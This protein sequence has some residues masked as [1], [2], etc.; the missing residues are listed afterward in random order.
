MTE[1][2]TGFLIGN[3][4]LKRGRLFRTIPLFMAAGLLL[5]SCA[6]KG[7]VFT[8]SLPP[9]PQPENLTLAPGDE[10][11]VRFPYFPEYDDTQII[12][13]DGK[14]S[15]PLIDEVQAEGLAPSELD[16]LLTNLYQE[17]I[18]E[19]DLTVVVRAQARKRVYVGGEVIF[20]GVIEW[21]SEMTVID[22]V[23]SAGGWDREHGEA[24]CVVVIRNVDG[25]YRGTTVDIRNALECKI[26]SPVYLAPDDIVYVPQTKISR[27]NQWV[28]Q[29]INRIFPFTPVTVTETRGASTV[30]LGL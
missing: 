14:I 19:P 26:G 8:G 16:W 9:L 25:R 18:Q 27:V 28:E 23:I 12:R 29:N 2:E 24:S 20:P 4:H 13:T 7:P 30:G 6:S 1:L 5:A 21:Q 11:E 3:M 15:L 22:A 17:K 10:I